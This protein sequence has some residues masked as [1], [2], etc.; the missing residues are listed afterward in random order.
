MN[1]AAWSD[2]MPRTSV[3][4]PT[5]N[6]PELLGTAIASVLRQTDQDFE[7]V[8]VDDGSP[9]DRTE[10]LV[11]GSRDARLHYIRLPAQRG[12]AAARNA[13][14]SAARGSYIA[15]LDD[16]DEWLPEKLRMQTG[17][18]AQCGREVGG[19]Y[20]ARLTIDSVTGSVSVTRSAGSFFDPARSHNLITTSSLLVRRACL[21]LAGPFDEQLEVGEDYDMWIRIG[22]AFRFEY[23]DVVLVKYYQRDRSRE[24]SKAARALERLLAKH[25]DLF[26][27]DRRVFSGRY[28]SLGLLYWRAGD[29]SNARRALMTAIRLWPIGPRSYLGLARTLR[30]RA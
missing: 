30:Q 11:R 14:L 21:D 22:L 28:L 9:D 20:T 27:T 18:L 8:V 24:A 1:E 5:H 25:R 10:R 13:G 15:F 23:L 12:V 2:R 6:R 7:V 3:V 19:V 17:V 4:M 26:A 29:L 16:D